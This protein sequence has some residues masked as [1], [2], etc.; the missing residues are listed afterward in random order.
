MVAPEIAR[1][2]GTSGPVVLSQED[3]FLGSD[4]GRYELTTTPAA[5]TGPRA[6]AAAGLN[7]ADI[8]YASIYDS[9][10]IT[11]LTAMEGIGFFEPGGGRDIL[12]DGGLLAPDGRIPVNT[13]GGG[14]AN[15]HPDRRGGMIRMI[16]AVRQLRGEA[17]PRLQIPHAEFALVHGSGHSLGSRAA[18][19]TAIL[20]R[21]D[22]A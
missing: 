21:G 19:S 6:L 9:F 13:D 1:D 2:L 8:D 4:N 15:N 17:H 14:L 5:R 18:V 12:R 11:V 22:A 7:A 10:T 3:A 20:Q 16:E